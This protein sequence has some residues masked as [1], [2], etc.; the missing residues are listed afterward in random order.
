MMYSGYYQDYRGFLDSSGRGSGQVFLYL[1][2]LGIIYEISRSRL[3][4]ANQPYRFRF[5]ASVLTS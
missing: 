4:K 2:D 3:E 1:H 5:Y